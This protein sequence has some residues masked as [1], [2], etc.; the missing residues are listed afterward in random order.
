MLERQGKERILREIGM[1]MCNYGKAHIPI[2]NIKHRTSSWYDQ[3]YHIICN[4]TEKHASV[5]LFQ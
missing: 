3:L 4:V 5:L 2:K 1:T